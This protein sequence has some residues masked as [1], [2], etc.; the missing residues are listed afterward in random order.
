MLNGIILLKNVIFFKKSSI[1]IYKFKKNLTN[2]NFFF[3]NKFNF[4]FK[5]SFLKFF[6]N[7]FLKNYIV[8]NKAKRSYKN[9]TFLSVLEKIRYLKKNKLKKKKIKVKI[10]KKKYKNYRLKRIIYY[11]FGLLKKNNFKKKLLLIRAVV[12]CSGNLRFIKKIKK[13]FRKY[14]KKK[15]LNMSHRYRFGKKFFKKNKND[16]NIIYR[17]YKHIINR[18]KKIFNI[19][20][21][22]FKKIKKKFIFFKIKKNIL[23]KYKEYK[24]Y[25]FNKTYIGKNIIFIKQSKFLV[26]KKNEKKNNIFFFK[27]I[28]LNSFKKVF[29]KSMFFNL[30]FISKKMLFKVIK[31]NIFSTKFTNYSN[32]TDIVFFKKKI[33]NLIKYKFKKQQASKYIY[34]NV[35]F[36]KNFFEFFLKK[37]TIIIINNLKKVNLKKSKNFKALIKKLKNNL[38]KLKP[39]LMPKEVIRVVTSMVKNKDVDIFIDWFV[40]FLQKT[41]LKKHKKYLRVIKKVFLILKKK[42]FR[43]NK[44]KGLYL[45]IKGKVGVSG[46]AKKRKFL[47]KL[48]KQKFFNKIDKIVWNSRQIKTITGA[49][50][51]KVV[52]SY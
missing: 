2:Y 15:L 5:F 52:I 29:F 12:F 11:L 10:F 31:K 24:K 4:F 1:Y 18:S 33:I 35:L 44:L 32:F 17:V 6:F 47:I 41:N 36:F 30:G 34:F 48:G 38:N 3:F 21:F 43:K 28:L 22:F 25:S 51:L 42:I 23:F 46:N 16:K 50:G 20:I 40:Y 19:K 14:R 27:K 49:L 7:F 37:K 8:F 26:K 39:H 9:V 45:C 13:Y